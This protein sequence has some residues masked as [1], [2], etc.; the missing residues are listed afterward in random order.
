MSRRKDTVP[1]GKV[2]SSDRQGH[3]VYVETPHMKD[4]PDFSV[5]V[6]GLNPYLTAG[7]RDLELLLSVPVLIVHHV[8]QFHF[9][10]RG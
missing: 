9:Q 8:R 3:V 10:A 2:I 1:N 7:L 4:S 6:D 5:V